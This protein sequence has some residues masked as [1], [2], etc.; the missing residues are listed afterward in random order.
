MVLPIPRR[1]LI[2]AI[3]VI[4]V[5]AL[6]AVFV[7][8]ALFQKPLRIYVTASLADGST[9]MIADSAPS[10]SIVTYNGKIVTAFHFYTTF[11]GTSSSGYTQY[12]LSSNDVGFWR[13]SYGATRCDQISISAQVTRTPPSPFAMGKTYNLGDYV[14]G[15]SGTPQSVIDILSSRIVS[16]SVLCAGDASYQLIYSIS[17]TS[18]VVGV[19][20][21]P[22]ST[23]SG[24]VAVPIAV[25]AGTMTLSGTVT[26]TATNLGG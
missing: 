21:L 5:V 12:T 22:T 20:T 4:I 9:V 16:S 7:L 13:M 10:L 2:A 15:G 8:P 14:I 11:Q 3:A 18:Q 17:M 1:I 24:S 23:W 26:F 19:G 25:I 6:V